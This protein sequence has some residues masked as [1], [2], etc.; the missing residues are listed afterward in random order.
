MR[1]LNITI[2][3]YLAAESESCPLMFSLQVDSIGWFLTIE[4]LLHLSLEKS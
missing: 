1:P 4:Q 3:K 2:Y